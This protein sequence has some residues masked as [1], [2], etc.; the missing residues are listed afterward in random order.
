M[1]N[2]LCARQTTGLVVRGLPLGPHH[3]WVG[4]GSIPVMQALRRGKPCLVHT[5]AE[6]TFPTPVLGPQQPQLYP[7]LVAWITPSA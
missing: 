4:D 1:S 3:Q 6:L 5:W 7:P 2:L